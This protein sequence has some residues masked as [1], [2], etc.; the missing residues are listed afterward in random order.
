M[1]FEYKKKIIIFTLKF[2][3]LKSPEKEFQFKFTDPMVQNNAVLIKERLLLWCRAKTKEY[4]V[5][6][7]T[8]LQ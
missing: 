5:I 8:L 1:N 6:N 7:I 2:S 3:T 4:E